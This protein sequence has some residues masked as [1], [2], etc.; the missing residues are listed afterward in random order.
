MGVLNNAGGSLSLCFDSSAIDS[1]SWDKSTVE[2]P[3][4]FSPLTSRGDNS[5]GFVGKVRGGDAGA[6]EFTVSGRIFRMGG[7]PPRVR[8]VSETAV[9]L[10]LL[11]SAGRKVWSGNADSNSSVWREIPLQK[12]GNVGVNYVRVKSGN[13]EKVVGIVLRP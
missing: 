9:E 3:S 13:Y 7:P 11:D 12:F 4:G 8:V 1:V 5:P 6:V 2:C 10:G